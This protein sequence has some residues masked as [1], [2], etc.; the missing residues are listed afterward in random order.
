MWKLQ[1]YDQ[2]NGVQVEVDGNEDGR[3]GRLQG[4][5]AFHP[6]REIRVVAK[7]VDQKFDRVETVETSLHQVGQE[8]VGFGP[9]EPVQGQVDVGAEFA[10]QESSQILENEF[11]LVRPCQGL[12]VR[13]WDCTDT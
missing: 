9:E 11:I 13:T 1:I 7:L 12:G 4:R 6:Q 5:R 2:P 3:E 8:R 10:D